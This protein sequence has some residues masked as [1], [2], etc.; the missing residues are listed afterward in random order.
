MYADGQNLVGGHQLR[1]YNPT[2][3]LFSGFTVP[4]NVTNGQNQR[5]ILLGDTM[6]PGSPDFTIAGMGTSLTNFASAGAACWDT[7]DC[8]SWGTFSGN[9]NLPSPAGTPI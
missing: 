1:I 2:G 4:G 8:V 7:V 6:A 3:T 9:A 5:R